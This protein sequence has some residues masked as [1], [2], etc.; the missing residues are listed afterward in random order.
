[1]GKASRDREGTTR[2][3][4]GRGGGDGEGGGRQPNGRA[5]GG[6]DGEG[7]GREPNGRA[8]GGGDGEGGGREPNEWAR[9]GGDGEGGGREPNARADVEAGEEADVGARMGASGARLLR[10]HSKSFAGFS[11]SRSS[12]RSLSLRIESV[13]CRRE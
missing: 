2:G 13:T 9:G 8:R 3:R 4:N 10:L 7:G 5:R 6:G 11:L 1:M 12:R